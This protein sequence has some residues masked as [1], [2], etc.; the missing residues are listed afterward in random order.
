MNKVKK[1]VYTLAVMIFT[2]IAFSS[3]DKNDLEPVASMG[4]GNEQS[5]D[6]SS[7]IIGI[8]D[9]KR[10]CSYPFAGTEIENWKWESRKLKTD[11]VSDKKY[12]LWAYMKKT[13]AMHSYQIKAAFQNLSNANIVVRCVRV[14][15][16]WISH[17][18][19]ELL[20]GCYT[21]KKGEMHIFEELDSQIA[22]SN[23]YG[24]QYEVIIPSKAE[25][26]LSEIEIK[27]GLCSTTSGVWNCLF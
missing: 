7:D 27:S 9:S 22:P 4:S 10:Y 19:Y 18:E 15:G 25:C 14:L 11:P 12:Y 1:L 21:L 13:D 24:L 2:L 17:D 3:Y 5:E 8:T 26:G 16:N 6:F 20:E 23:S